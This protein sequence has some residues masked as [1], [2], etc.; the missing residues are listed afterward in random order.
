MLVITTTIIQIEALGKSRIFT[1]KKTYS[2]HFILSFCM[3][4]DKRNTFRAFKNYKNSI[5]C[6]INTFLD[7]VVLQLQKGLFVFCVK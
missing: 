7:I 6:I 5:L 1:I 2:F 4:N 3:E